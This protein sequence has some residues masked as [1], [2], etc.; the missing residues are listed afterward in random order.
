MS[1]RRPYI[2]SIPLCL[3]LCSF[4]LVYIIT[5]F[6]HIFNIENIYGTHRRL[7]HCRE[8]SP[9]PPENGTMWASSPTASH[10][11]ILGR[12]SVGEGLRALPKSITPSTTFGGPPS[13]KRKAGTMLASSP[14]G[15][16][17]S[18]KRDV[19]GAVPYGAGKA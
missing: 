7:Y 11:D 19:G 8:G 9:C 17:K 6:I 18:D 14:T 16:A 10:R 15:Y 1:K 4:N 2:T 12:T 13:S 5:Y 3:Y